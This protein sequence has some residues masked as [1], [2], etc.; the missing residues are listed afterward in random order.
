MYLTG[1]YIG[2]VI[3]ETLL[4]CKIFKD[5][6]G[7]NF[8]FFLLFFLIALTV[9]VLPIFALIGFVQNLFQNK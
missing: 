8:T 7:L 2:V 1:V 6:I 9:F 3:V 5:E 4:L